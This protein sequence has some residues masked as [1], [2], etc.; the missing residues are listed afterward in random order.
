MPPVATGRLA[1]AGFPV[2]II[3]CDK[4]EGESDVES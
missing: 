4:F 2:W 3:T 1:R